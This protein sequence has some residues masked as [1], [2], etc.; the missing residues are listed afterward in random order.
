MAVPV[1]LAGDVV[2][3]NDLVRSTIVA[4]DAPFFNKDPFSTGLGGAR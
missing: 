4:V 2:F 1:R 3:R